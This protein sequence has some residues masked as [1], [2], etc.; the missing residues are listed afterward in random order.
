MKKRIRLNTPLLKHPQGKEL[1]I[2]F[3]DGV[4]VDRFWRRRFADA[5]VDN[6]IELVKPVKKGT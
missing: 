2:E 1:D 4:P 5:K 3:A 6:C